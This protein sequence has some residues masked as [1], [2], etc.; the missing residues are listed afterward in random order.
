MRI[1]I[2]LFLFS[3]CMLH[4]QDKR[5][6][7]FP[8]IP[9]YQ[10]II[11]DL[12]MHTVFS[13]GSVWPDIR[14]YEA[15]RDG[16]DLIATTEHLEYQP[17]SEDI[18]HSNRNRSFMIASRIALRDSLMV[19]NGSEIT[20]SMPPGHSN[21][22]FIQDANALLNDDVKEVFREANRQG[23]FTFWNHP[24]WSSQYKDGIARLSDLHKE[25]ISENLLH[26]IE[27]VNEHM[28]S[29]EALQIALDNNLT[30]LGT[31]DIHGLIDWEFEVPEGGH[32]PVTLIFSKD[33]TSDA[34]RN[35][36]FAG[37]TAVW[38]KDLLI[39]KEENLLPLIRAS[40]QVT[41][42]EY[43]NEI[44][45]VE[46]ENRSSA[47]FM[48]ENLSEFNLHTSSEIIGIEAHSSTLVEV[49]TGGI[50]NEFELRFRVLNA[51]TAPRQHPEIGLEMQYYER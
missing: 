6:I 11:S 49:K 17:H 22:I 1:L 34:I 40:I 9:G 31:S 4:A 26:G 3:T 12:H 28:F 16:L 36:L 37:R 2:L 50:V 21:A 47:P 38:F 41:S 30:I 44:A 15:V 13:D 43:Q 5:E 20:R 10:T 27:V 7:D 48:L 29:D 42:V 46:I 23:A 24:M 51:I 8:D 25:L 39:G 32:R 19:I 33:K 45:V 14:V 35:A 18:P